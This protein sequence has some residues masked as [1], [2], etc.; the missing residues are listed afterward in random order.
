MF[1]RPRKSYDKPR[2]KGYY[3]I[4]IIL[5][6]PRF[7]SRGKTSNAGSNGH[8]SSDKLLPR[9]TNMSE[10]SSPNRFPKALASF[11]LYNYN[12]GELLKRFCARRSCN[13]SCKRQSGTLLVESIVEEKSHKETTN[14][15]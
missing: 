9:Y 14:I 1:I 15:E 7:M 6:Q 11:D 5:Q 8:S 2:A 3:D 13:R 4:S 10:E 12:P